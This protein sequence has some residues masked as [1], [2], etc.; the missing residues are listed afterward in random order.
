M[1]VFDDA[2]APCVVLGN[3]AGE[4]SLW[5]AAGEVPGGWRMVFGPADRQAC[6]AHV[7]RIWTDLGT[8]VAPGGSGVSA[9][10]AGSGG[11]Q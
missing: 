11:P 10:A 7:G 9:S 6:L 3:E 1:N 5:P 4:Y 8:S 2:A